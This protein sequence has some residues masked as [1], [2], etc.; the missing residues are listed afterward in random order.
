[1]QVCFVI[2]PAQLKESL[3]HRLVCFVIEPAQLEESLQNHCR[4]FFSRTFKLEESL[5]HCSLFCYKNCTW[6][7]AC[8][9]IVVVFK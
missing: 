6:R 9:V 1:M 2:E 5:H 8:N 7:K 3:Q 4:L